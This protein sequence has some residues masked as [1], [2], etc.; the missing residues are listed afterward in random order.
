MDPERPAHWKDAPVPERE[1]RV[2]VLPWS[3]IAQSNHRLV[4]RASGKGLTLSP[5]YRR[6]LSAARRAVAVQVEAQGWPVLTGPVSV[7]IHVYP[8]NRRRMDGTNLGKL[9]YDALEGPK[10]PGLP[11]VYEDDAQVV[12]WHGQKMEPDRE[13]PRAV[14]T[15]T[16]WARAS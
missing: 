7:T 11:G 9:I 13:N 4:P 8:P 6:A 14:V 1:P 3:A 16:A 10:E 15:V 12:S 2:I 5:G